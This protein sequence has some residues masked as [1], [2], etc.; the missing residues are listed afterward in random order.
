MNQFSAL[1]QAYT[2]T[3]R[4]R[5]TKADDDVWS[6]LQAVTR[7]VDHE[8]SVRNVNQDDANDVTVGRFAAATFGTGNDLKGN[9]FNM[10]LPMIAD[11]VKVAA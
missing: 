2:T 10:L 8:R 4:E 5:N 3:K 1:S 9:A 6:A 7:Y 11:K